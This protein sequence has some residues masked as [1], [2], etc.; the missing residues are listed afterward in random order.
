M[1]QKINDL[2][3]TAQEIQKQTSIKAAEKAKS[4]SA[5]Q[6]RQRTAVDREAK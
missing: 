1:S 5:R 6:P 2:L 3:P 4:V